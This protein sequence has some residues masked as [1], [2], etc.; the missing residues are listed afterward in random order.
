MSE[1]SEL[2]EDDIQPEIDGLQLVEIDLE[3]INEAAKTDAVVCQL[4][5]LL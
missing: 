4:L 3:G 2:F 5:H 1:L